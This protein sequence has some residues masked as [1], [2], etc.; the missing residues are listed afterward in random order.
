MDCDIVGKQANGC[1]VTTFDGKNAYLTE[2]TST[3]GAPRI[4]GKW[5]G[6]AC[7]DERVAP[8]RL[9]ANASTVIAVVPKA[10]RS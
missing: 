10:H 1:G 2:G 6:R 5:W 4:D 9:L 7:R 3:Q 8:I